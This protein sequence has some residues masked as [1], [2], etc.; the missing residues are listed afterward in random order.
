MQGYNGSETGFDKSLG[1][2]PVRVF[3]LIIGNGERSAFRCRKR[4]MHELCRGAWFNPLE[5]PV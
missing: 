2:W 3:F 4:H 5:D 1:A